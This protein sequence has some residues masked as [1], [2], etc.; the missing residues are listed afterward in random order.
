M[1]FMVLYTY[2]YQYVICTA[3][4]NTGGRRFDKKNND[5][6]VVKNNDRKR[7][8]R[9]CSATISI[10]RETFYYIIRYRVSILFP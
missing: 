6:Y 1:Y 8:R 7:R 5:K 3:V 9:L 2:T 10:N 4:Y